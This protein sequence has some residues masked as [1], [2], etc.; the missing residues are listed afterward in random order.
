[1]SENLGVCLL[2]GEIKLEAADMRLCR[3]DVAVQTDLYACEIWSLTRRENMC[4]LQ[5]SENAKCL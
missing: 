4:S 5:V 2:F 3:L 1:M